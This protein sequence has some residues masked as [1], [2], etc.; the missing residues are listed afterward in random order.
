MPAPPHIRPSE[1]KDADDDFYRTGGSHSPA[2]DL[3]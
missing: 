2:R 3:K 1:D